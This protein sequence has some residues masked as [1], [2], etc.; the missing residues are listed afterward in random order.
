[1]STPLSLAS[2]LR[3]GATHSAPKLLAGA[4]KTAR[5]A[6]ARGLLIVRAD[7][8]FYRYDVLVTIPRHK[9]RFSVT[10]R[11]DPSVRKAISQIPGDTWV[12]IPYPSPVWDEAAQEWISDTEVAEIDYTAFTSRRLGEQISGCL[13]VHRLKRLNP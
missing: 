9:A 5:A 4:L 6:G 7:N 3:K 12:A 11:Q 10:A 1:L 13:I 2:R 8:A